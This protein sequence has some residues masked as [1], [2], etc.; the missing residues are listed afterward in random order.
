M[1]TNEQEFDLKWKSSKNIT[2]VVYV[3]TLILMDYEIKYF[4]YLRIK[5]EEHVED[6]FSD[7]EDDR[8]KNIYKELSMLK[9]V[10]SAA[11]L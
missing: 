4:Q 3:G 2:E 9:F 8:H 7:D 1:D 10:T 5:V 6:Q 11:K